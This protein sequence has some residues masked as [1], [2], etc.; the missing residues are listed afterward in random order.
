MLKKRRYNLIIPPI[1]F[2]WVICELLFL[3]VPNIA[4]HMAQLTKENNRS[5]REINDVLFFIRLSP[6]IYLMHDKERRRNQ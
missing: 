4:L 3:F 5:K 1:L 2:T 6:T